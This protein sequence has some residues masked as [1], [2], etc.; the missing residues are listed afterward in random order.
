MATTNNLEKKYV[1]AV[2]DP[3]QTIGVDAGTQAASPITPASTSSVP[4]GS[5]IN[6]VVIDTK[7]AFTGGSHTLQ[8]KM[9]GVNITKATSISERST[10][11]PFSTLL[12]PVVTTNTDPI[13]V[14][15]AAADIA[16]TNVGYCRIIIGYFPPVSS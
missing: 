14:T 1:S 3:R 15:I 7:A 8:V 11:V 13:N 12:G 2:Y 4:V 5:V 9:G 6:S 10:T 16:G